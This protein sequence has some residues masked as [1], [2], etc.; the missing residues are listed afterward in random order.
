MSASPFLL[1]LIGILA[2]SLLAGR[3]AHRFGLPAVFGTLLLGLLLGP[4]VQ[5]WIMRSESL[6]NLSQI[7]VLLLMF[8]AGLET[9]LDEM[10]RL[11]KAPLLVATGGVLLPLVG[12][13]ALSLLFGFGLLPSLFIGTILTATSVSISAQTLKE[14]GKLQSREGTVILGAAVI[15]DVLGILVLSLV[16]G[17]QGG[18]TA[19]G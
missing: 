8:L 4:S 15:D 9:D 2:G 16:V 13:T 11:G 5:G 19:S 3:L 10:R 14:L 18:E 12:G 1:S 6:G 17:M 7:G